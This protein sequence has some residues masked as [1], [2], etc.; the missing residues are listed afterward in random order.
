V[1]SPSFLHPPSN[2]QFTLSI[3][4][5]PGGLHMF[6]DLSLFAESCIKIHTK[7]LLAVRFPVVSCFLNTWNTAEEAPTAFS[8]RLCLNR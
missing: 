4:D 5:V 7:E 2:H 6:H 1:N 3:P 8:T